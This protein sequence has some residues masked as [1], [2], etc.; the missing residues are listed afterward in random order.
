MTA[1][2]APAFHHNTH[3]KL[4]LSAL[5]FPSKPVSCCKLDAGLQCI[6]PIYR[7]HSR[8]LYSCALSAMMHQPE[9]IKAVEPI[10]INPAHQFA[11]SRVQRQEQSGSA[12]VC[13][14][15]LVWCMGLSPLKKYIQKNRAIQGFPRTI[16]THPTHH[17]FLSRL[18]RGRLKIKDLYTGV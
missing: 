17:S 13:S 5:R 3:R 12:S 4:N 15:Q 18:E 16:L 11:S 6:H 8:V 2:S 9:G 7:R 1:C 10:L 14:L